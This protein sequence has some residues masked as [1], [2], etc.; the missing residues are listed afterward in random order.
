MDTDTL[1]KQTDELFNA[2]GDAVVRFQQVEHWLADEL[3]STLDMRDSDAA[4][5]VSASMSFKQKV[6]LLMEL[7]PT[8]RPIEAMN[9]DLD[10]VFQALTASEIYRNL[11]VHSYWAI[12]Q[13]EWR[14]MKG[15]V[16][17]KNGY[18]FSTEKAAIQTLVKCNLALQ[19]VRN[20]AT[21]SPEKLKQ[22]TAVLRSSKF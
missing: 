13:E 6:S 1:I 20:W 4:Y 14:R 9:I 18:S 15:S 17:G 22:A 10:A 11:V 19:D 16:R 8:K 12:A 3:A 5:L 21:I 2:I 7:F